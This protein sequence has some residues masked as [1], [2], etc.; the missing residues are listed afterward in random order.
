M[1][2]DDIYLQIIIA[3]SISSLFNSTRNSIV[4][5]LCWEI[6]PVSFSCIAANIREETETQNKTFKQSGKSTISTN[7]KDRNFEFDHHWRQSRDTGK[8]IKLRRF[9]TMEEKNTGRKWWLESFDNKLLDGSTGIEGKT[10]P[11]AISSDFSQPRLPSRASLYPS[12]SGRFSARG[13]KVS[14]PVYTFER[15]PP[16]FPP[17]D[18]ILGR[19]PASNASGA[20]LP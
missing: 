3:S 1:S 16:L 18:A 20:A 9:S 15:R 5:T 14:W 13:G 7:S 4:N 6:R 8:Q 11:R 2:I 12:S 10:C 19:W 17:L